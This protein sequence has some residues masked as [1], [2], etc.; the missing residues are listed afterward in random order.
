MNIRT[1]SAPVGSASARVRSGEIGST[2]YIAA[3]PARKGPNEV[4]SWRT[5][6]ACIGCAKAAAAWRTSISERASRSRLILYPLLWEQAMLPKW[7]FDRNRTTAG[8]AN[9]CRK[10]HMHTVDIRTDD[11]AAP[12]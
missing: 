10:A 1:S 8:L 3:Q 5:P 7:C 4:R 9:A 2:R 6:L 12:L 11:L